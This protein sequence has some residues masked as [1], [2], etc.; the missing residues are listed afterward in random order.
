MAATNSKHDCELKERQ[1][2][3]SSRIIFCYACVST[4]IVDTVRVK[5]VPLRAQK[6]RLPLSNLLIKSNASAFR[7]L[8]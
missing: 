7:R 6:K 5:R 2:R 3:A 8:I 4:K 1:G